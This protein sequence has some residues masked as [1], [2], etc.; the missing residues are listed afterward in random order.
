MEMRGLLE[1]EGEVRRDCRFSKVPG[2][3]QGREVGLRRDLL[4]I[5][6]A[7]LQY[8][9]HNPKDSDHGNQTRLIAVIREFVCR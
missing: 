1:S 9:T 3:V 5:M 2:I 7:D 4:L 8:P 6:Q